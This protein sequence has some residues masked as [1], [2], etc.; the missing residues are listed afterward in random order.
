MELGS[1]YTWQMCNQGKE[2]YMI[3]LGRGGGSYQHAAVYSSKYPAL[4][5]TCNPDCC[6]HNP[7]I[8]CQAHTKLS[9]AH[10]FPLAL[11]LL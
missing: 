6:T 10:G 4:T 3:Q 5:L 1:T 2:Q 9:S 7:V 11:P 8:V